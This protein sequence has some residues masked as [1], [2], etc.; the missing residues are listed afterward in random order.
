MRAPPALV[1]VAAIVAPLASAGCYSVPDYAQASDGGIASADGPWRDGGSDGGSGSSS[2]ASSGSGGSSGSSS[3]GTSDGSPAADA[4][5]THVLCACNNNTD[6]A[7]G[8]CAQEI[9]VGSGLYAAAGGTNFCTQPCCTSSDCP[10]GTVCFASGAGG[11][12]CVDPAW[13]GRAKPAAGAVNGGSACSSGS[14]CRSGICSGST[15]ADTCCSLAQ[16]SSECTSPTSCVLG[17]FPGMSSIDTHFAPHCGAAGPNPFAAACVSNSDCQGGVCIQTGTG[18]A[19]TGPCR[20]ENECES[21]ASCEFYNQGNDVY[22]ACFPL[23][24]GQ[25]SGGIGASCTAD[26][27]CL[28]LYCNMGAS[29]GQCSGPCFTSSD[30]MAVQGWRCTPQLMISFSAGNYTVLGCGP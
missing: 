26:T 2:G 24:M 3:G 28:G 13:I 6:C 1:T 17:A 30:C 25:G 10:D 19:C 4:S 18:G 15:C 11:Q 9:N 7:S 14:A 22:A 27:Q 16:S 23:A 5:C 21:G 8:V 29:G 20:G 12:Y